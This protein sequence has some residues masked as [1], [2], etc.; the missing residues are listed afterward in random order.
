MLIAE[1][2]EE[3]PPSVVEARETGVSY[4]MGDATINCPCR[5]SSRLVVYFTYYTE[6]GVNIAT[7]ITSDGDE[8]ETRL[9][10]YE[11]EYYE[12]PEN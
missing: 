1:G 3:V 2:W 12:Y 9:E 8:K 6:N 10:D 11:Y 4:Y 7:E 5:I